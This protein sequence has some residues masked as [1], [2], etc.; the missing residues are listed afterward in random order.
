MTQSAAIEDRFVPSFEY[1]DV[2]E[3]LSQFPAHRPDFGNGAI[4]PTN[5]VATPGGS[6]RRVLPRL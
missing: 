5:G 2:A 4:H 6:L 1:D 3:P